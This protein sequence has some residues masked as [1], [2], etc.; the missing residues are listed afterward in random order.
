MR[1]LI[2]NSLRSVE[3]GLG[4]FGQ[5]KKPQPT[6]AAKPK[7][8]SHSVVIAAWPELCQSST[9]VSSGW[10]SGLNN[11]ERALLQWTAKKISIKSHLGPT[12]HNKS[13][14]EIVVLFR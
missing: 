12:L 5:K 8:I 10:I 3:V 6:T 9:V 13:A 7:A 14:V 4:L 2:L 1:S 11:I